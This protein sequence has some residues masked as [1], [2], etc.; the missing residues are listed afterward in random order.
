MPFTPHETAD[1]RAEWRPKLKKAEV[2]MTGYGNRY[3]TCMDLTQARELADAL[4]EAIREADDMMTAADGPLLGDLA[5][6]IECLSRTQR[7]ALA[8][9]LGK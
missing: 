7:E 1:V 2:V 5:K 4:A 9:I 3:P 8:G 6:Q